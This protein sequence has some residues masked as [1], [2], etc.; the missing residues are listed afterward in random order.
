MHAWIDLFHPL[1]NELTTAYF[2]LVVVEVG[3]ELAEHVA[4]TND[5]L[6]DF[7]LLG[8]QLHILVLEVFVYPL[9]IY[10]VDAFVDWEESGWPLIRVFT[11][12]GDFA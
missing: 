9:A 7:A 3:E 10:S 4:V 5:T 12:G 2:L 11:E 6:G 8:W 1:E